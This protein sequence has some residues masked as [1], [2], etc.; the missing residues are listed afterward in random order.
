MV[1]PRRFNTKV[2]IIFR[3][4]GN[5]RKCLST[6]VLF[7][8]EKGRWISAVDSFL[9][10][11]YLQTTTCYSPEKCLYFWGDIR[12]IKVGFFEFSR[13]VSYLDYGAVELMYVADGYILNINNLLSV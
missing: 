3:Y 13:D 12:G 9:Y 1:N 10:Y 7:E 11:K 6:T 5:L 2:T 8:M 4:V